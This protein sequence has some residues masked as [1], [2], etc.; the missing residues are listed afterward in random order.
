MRTV[1]LDHFYEAGDKSETQGGAASPAV[2]PRYAL[3]EG[4]TC[5]HVDA[6]ARETCRNWFYKTACIRELL[7]RIVIEARREI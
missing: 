3:P 7:P 6:E 4:W 2:P 1:I 5:D